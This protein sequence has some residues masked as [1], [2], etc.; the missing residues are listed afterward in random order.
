V[1]ATRR[2]YPRFETSPPLENS[3]ELPIFSPG[4]VALP[5]F[6][7]KDGKLRLVWPGYDDA[8]VVEPDEVVRAATR[9]LG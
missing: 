2:F 8:E 5:R 7:R 6:A 3:C 1:K 9:E 4:E